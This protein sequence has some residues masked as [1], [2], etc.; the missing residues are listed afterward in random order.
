MVQLF[1]NGSINPLSLL[2]KTVVYPNLSSQCLPEVGR[3]VLERGPTYT[4]LEL[5]K[6]KLIK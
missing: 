2:W 4:L 3:V 5:N 1:V 6:S